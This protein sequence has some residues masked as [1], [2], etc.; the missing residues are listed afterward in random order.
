MDVENAEFG[1]V[2]FREFAESA[3]NFEI[4]YYV[5]SKDYAVYMD[6][7]QDI[8]LGMA[9]AFEKAKIEMAFPTQTIYLKK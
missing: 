2:H 5:L 4:V 3:L 8:N 1:R 7:Q 6:V 9:A